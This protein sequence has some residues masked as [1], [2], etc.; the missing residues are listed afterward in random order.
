MFLLWVWQW[1]CHQHQLTWISFLVSSLQLTWS[2]Q[3]WVSVA[4]GP[5]FYEYIWVLHH[6]ANLVEFIL[7]VWGEE[8]EKF[9]G[10]LVLPSFWG[11]EVSCHSMDLPKPLK[12]TP[13]A[14]VLALGEPPIILPAAAC[15]KLSAVGL[16][17][18]SGS[19]CSCVEEN[20]F[21][22]ELFS[23][24]IIALYSTFTHFEMPLEIGFLGVIWNTFETFYHLIIHF[25]VFHKGKQFWKDLFLCK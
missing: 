16:L 2:F 4:M 7:K 23:F 6:V 12:I 14:T 20:C 10:L 8:E 25:P 15:L 13:R 24:H 1:W 9:Q 5:A 22:W 19:I 3:T 18:L 11:N 17:L 21:C